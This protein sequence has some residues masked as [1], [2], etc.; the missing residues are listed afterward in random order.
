MTQ[1]KQIIIIMKLKDIGMNAMKHVKL[2]ILMD[3]KIGKD[4]QNVNQDIIFL[5]L[6]KIIH[7]VIAI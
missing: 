1:I 5:I 7:M 2:A 3:L 6:I 4:V